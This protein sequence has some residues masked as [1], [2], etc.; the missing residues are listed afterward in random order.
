MEEDVRL[1]S[2]YCDPWEERVISQMIF[3]PQHVYVCLDHTFSEGEAVEVELIFLPDLED[4]ENRREALE[5]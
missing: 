1:D 3:P 4:V 5:R 2:G